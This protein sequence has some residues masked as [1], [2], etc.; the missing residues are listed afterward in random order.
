MKC[1]QRQ[2][3]SRQGLRKKTMALTPPIGWTQP[4]SGGMGTRWEKESSISQRI[5]QGG[6]QQRQGLGDCAA[7]METGQ[8]G[9][10]QQRADRAGA[11][12]SRQ[13]P[14]PG[15]GREE[16]RAQEPAPA[17]LLGRGGKE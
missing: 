16:E 4:S 10:G 17:G 14:Q 12:A 1:R 3:T 13:H 9:Q 2:G 6:R 8:P 7:G 15:R 11:E 5:V